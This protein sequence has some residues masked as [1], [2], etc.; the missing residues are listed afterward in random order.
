[1]DT[2]VGT[3]SKIPP[4]VKRDLEDDTAEAFMLTLV[5]RLL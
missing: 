2:G 5:Y 4:L 1:M 3:Y